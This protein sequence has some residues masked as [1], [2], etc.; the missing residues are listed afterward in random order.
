MDISVISRNFLFDLENGT[1]V[2][3]F[4]AKTHPLPRKGSYP[5]EGSSRFPGIVL[6]QTSQ[7]FFSTHNSVIPAR[8]SIRQWEQ[9]P[10]LPTLVIA[11]LVVMGHI[12][13]QGSAQHLSPNKISFD[14]HSCFTDLTQR[15]AKT[16]GKAG[17]VAV[18]LI[19]HSVL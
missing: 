8:P 16:S 13:L 1:M 10:V 19:E 7:S 18:M 4:M 3:A 14:R 17:G 9:Q 6:Q 15:S 11:L 5:T 2:Y 12:F